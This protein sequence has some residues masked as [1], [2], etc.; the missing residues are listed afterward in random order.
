M[1]LLVVM[2]CLGLNVLVSNAGLRY[3]GPQLN[4]YM[5][6]I[7]HGCEFQKNLL[8]LVIHILLLITLRKTSTNSNIGPNIHT[9]MPINT[10]I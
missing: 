8:I 4:I 3:L 6:R 9:L 10:A 1:I 5:C 7:S 2:N